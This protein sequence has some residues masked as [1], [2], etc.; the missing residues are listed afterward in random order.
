MCVCVVIVWGELELVCDDV[1]VVLVCGVELYIYQG[2][3]DVMEFF[4]G[5]VGEVG[6][7]FEGVCFFGVVVVFW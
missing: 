2:M 5:L 7:Y 6:S 4:V 3:L 1:Y